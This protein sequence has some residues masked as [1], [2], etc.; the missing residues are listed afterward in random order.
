M[1]IAFIYIQVIAGIALPSAAPDTKSTHL[2]H[3]TDFLPYDNWKISVLKCKK[4][5]KQQSKNEVWPAFLWEHHSITRLVSWVFSLQKIG[6]FRP[7]EKCQR[8]KAWKFVKPS[9]SQGSTLRACVAPAGHSS[10]SLSLWKKDPVKANT[11]PP[12]ARYKIQIAL[13]D[14]TASKLPLRLTTEP[15]RAQPGQAT[16]A[17][18]RHFL[19][20]HKGSSSHL[21]SARFPPAGTLLLFPAVPPAPGVGNEREFVMELRNPGQRW[22]IM[23]GR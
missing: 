6:S 20:L 23:F 12:A 3:L 14:K 10:A 19:Q 16:H 13:G 7:R 11:T 15:G 1:S 17:A 22:G 8:S 18:P 9:F 2:K 5:V 21:S 4:C